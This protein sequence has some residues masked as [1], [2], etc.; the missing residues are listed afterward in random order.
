MNVL[1]KTHEDRSGDWNT[2]D[3]PREI[4]NKIQISFLLLLLN[5]ATASEK[6]FQMLA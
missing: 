6:M 3:N 5:I 1:G 4:D 2:A